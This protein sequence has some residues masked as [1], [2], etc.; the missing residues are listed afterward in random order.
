M[1]DAFEEA[2]A[3]ELNARLAGEE[4]GRF[5]MPEL[6]AAATAHDTIGWGEA[7]RLVAGAAAD[8]V[9]ADLSSV[10]TAGIE[11]AA[12]VFA[13]AAADVTDVLIGGRWVVRDRAHQLIEAPE[14]VLGKEI[15]ELWRS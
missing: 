8:L 6:L 14:T 15:E 10:R 9:V 12:A 4:R 5:T 11:P 3:V 1:I 13:A 2:R 7:G